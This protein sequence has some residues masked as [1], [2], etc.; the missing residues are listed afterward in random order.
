MELNISR[1]DRMKYEALRWG[2]VA[3]SVI[4]ILFL[5]VRVVSLDNEVQGLRDKND[6][7]SVAL[8]IL[9]NVCKPTS[10][11]QRNRFQGWE[12]I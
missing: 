9:S 2:V 12:S 4:V 6:R 7:D 8:T 10:Q 1:E 11:L 5:F 3:V